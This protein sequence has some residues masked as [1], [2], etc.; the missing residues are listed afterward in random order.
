MAPFNPEYI[1]NRMQRS[2]RADVLVYQ[3][4]YEIYVMEY[5]K[6]PVLIGK[7]GKPAWLPDGKTVAYLDENGDVQSYTLDIPL[8]EKPVGGD[9]GHSS[10]V[11]QP[12]F[13]FTIGVEP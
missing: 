1:V 3:L 7:G 5:G 12:Q 8:S 11:L 9:L 6:A 10:I 13:F 2:P 4:G